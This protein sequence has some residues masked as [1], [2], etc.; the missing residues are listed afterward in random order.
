MQRRR[1]LSPILFHS[2]ST[3]PFAPPVFIWSCWLFPNPIFW[4]TL[5][6]SVLNNLGES[7]LHRAWKW[8]GKNGMTLV[9]GM[10]W[11]NICSPAFF[12]LAYERRSL[13]TPQCTLMRV[14]RVLYRYNALN[15]RSRS[16]SRLN[17]TK[18]SLVYYTRISRASGDRPSI[19]FHKKFARRFGFCLDH[20]VAVERFSGSISQ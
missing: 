7:I 12:S 11:F 6:N 17:I 13:K 19:G 5:E 18:L 14:L 20:F 2:R 3:Q 4:Q 9:S 10:P 1:R 15:T 16:R 8:H